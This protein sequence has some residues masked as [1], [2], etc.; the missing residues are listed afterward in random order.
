MTT[1][2]SWRE[3]SSSFSTSS[4]PLTLLLYSVLLANIHSGTIAAALGDFLLCLVRVALHPKMLEPK[5]CRHRKRKFLCAK[6][7]SRSGDLVPRDCFRTPSPQV[8]PPR[9]LLRSPSTRAGN[10][11]AHSRRRWACHTAPVPAGNAVADFWRRG[12]V[13]TPPHHGHVSV[14]DSEPERDSGSIVSAPDE[15]TTHLKRPRPDAG[16]HHQ[17]Q[18]Q[19]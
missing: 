11:V 4:L 14:A 1:W 15:S 9:E 3:V 10:A 13:T 7:S 5:Q 12:R 16:S 19:A 2:E 17:S 6:S 18:C 8:I